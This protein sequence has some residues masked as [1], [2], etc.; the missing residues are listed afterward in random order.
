MARKKVGKRANISNYV[1]DIMRQARQ[2]IDISK[3]QRTGRLKVCVTYMGP[4]KRA[5]KVCKMLTPKQI[6]KLVGIP[7]GLKI[8]KVTHF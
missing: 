7:R 3:R 4:K 2:E 6:A 8:T 1:N 5:R